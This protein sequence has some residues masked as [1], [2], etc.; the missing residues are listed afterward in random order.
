MKIRITCNSCKIENASNPKRY[1]YCCLSDKGLYK[2]RCDKGHESTVFIENHKF[3]IL[4]ESGILAFVDG[5]S[6][7]AVS[8]IASSLERFFEFYIKVVSLKNG[9]YYDKIS[10]SWKKIAAQSER[11]IGAY[12]FVYLL[13]NKKCPT[14]LSNKSKEL[15][16][17]VIHKGYIPSDIE[18]KKYAWNVAKIVSSEYLF[19][20]G[21]SDEIKQY[22]I[23]INGITAGAF[24]ED[25]N[26]I[27]VQQ[28][29]TLL[30]RIIESGKMEY[31]SFV[32]EINNLR[33][34]RES[35]LMNKLTTKT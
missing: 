22:T 23:G 4:F 31:E 7:E 24:E 34:E 28:E 5:Y 20:K 9:V 15:R 1:V 8:S 35:F 30:T 17:K 12:V 13:E 32:K 33:I 3:D 29:S 27:V 26:D 16:N 14:L 25:H 18:V 21:N 10:E 2:V 19:L 11:Q 6:R